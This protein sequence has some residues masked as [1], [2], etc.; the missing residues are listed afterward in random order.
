MDLIDSL[1][2]LHCDSRIEFSQSFPRPLS[3]EFRQTKNCERPSL[4]PP[5]KFQ[6][7]PNLIYGRVEGE[8]GQYRVE[9]WGRERIDSG[10]LERGSSYGCGRSRACRVG[11][12]ICKHRT[13]LQRRIRTGLEGQRRARARFKLRKDKLG[14]I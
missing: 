7:N 5:N 8:S 9:H 10:R 13:G 1:K 14:Q 4:T 2:Y 12:P 11:Q 6:L 3:R